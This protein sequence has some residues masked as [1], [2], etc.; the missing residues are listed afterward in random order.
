MFLIYIRSPVQWDI[1]LNFIINNNFTFG[2]ANRISSALTTM[3]G[4]Q[5]SDSM[6]IGF[7]YD[8][9]TTEIKKST[10]G[11]FEVLFRFD[12]GTNKK[13]LTPRFF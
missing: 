11:T 6:M 8:F 1:S 4:I 13:I 10:S 9:S 12:F 5:L 2:V 3:A 7:S